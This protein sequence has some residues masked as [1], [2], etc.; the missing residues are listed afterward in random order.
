MFQKCEVHGVLPFEEFPLQS[1][2]CNIQGLNTP[3]LHYIHPNP[4]NMHTLHPYDHNHLLHISLANSGQQQTA[5]ETNRHQMTPTDGTRHP[6][7]LFKDAWRLLLTLNGICWCLLV[8][9]DVF[10]CPMVS[11]GVSQRVS[12]CCLWTCL[13]F[14]FLLGSI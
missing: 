14:W 11:Y 5:T 8:S 2:C 13:R 12:E 10:Q 3:K 4:I 1:I 9:D 6:K 7:R